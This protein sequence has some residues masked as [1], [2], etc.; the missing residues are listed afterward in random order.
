MSVGRYVFNLFKLAN[1]AGNTL[2]G[3]SPEVPLSARAGY[4]QSKGYRQGKLFAG[5]INFLFRDKSHC[6]N[7][8]KKE[9]DSLTKYT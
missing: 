5:V 3:G 7:A 9:D 2:L 1:R 6:A 4:W 8:Y